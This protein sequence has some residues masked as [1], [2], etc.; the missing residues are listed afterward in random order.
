LPSDLPVE[1]KAISPI[2]GD[3][4]DFKVFGSQ[5]GGSFVEQG[6]GCAQ[7]Y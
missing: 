3:W 6:S 5:T 4:S 1:G 2:G 7:P